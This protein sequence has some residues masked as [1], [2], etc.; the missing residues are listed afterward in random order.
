[1]PEVRYRSLEE[2]AKVVEPLLSNLER[3]R[4]VCTQVGNSNT[5]VFSL[6]LQ[7]EQLD[8]KTIVRL[9][10]FGKSQV[11]ASLSKLQKLSLIRE[12]RGSYRPV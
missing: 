5:V 4:K 12:E 8:A 2:F 10:G 9:S 1:M 11:Y 7:N 3:L 6:I